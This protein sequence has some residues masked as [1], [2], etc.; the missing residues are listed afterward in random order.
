MSCCLYIDFSNKELE[1]KDLVCTDKVEQCF[2]W[3]C[4]FDLL[5]G[6]S[7]SSALQRRLKDREKEMEA[8]DRDRQREKEELEE[9]RRKLEEEGH[10][11]IEAEMARVCVYLLLGRQL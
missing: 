5:Y 9:I 10:P 7:R 1:Y 6:A 8:D 2:S 3:A 4:V 11:D